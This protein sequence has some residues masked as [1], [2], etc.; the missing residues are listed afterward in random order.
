MWASE[1]SNGYLYLASPSRNH[2][3]IKETEHCSL[4]HF[5][6]L[7]KSV[8]LRCIGVINIFCG[9]SAIHHN[10]TLS[11][12][13][14]LRYMHKGIGVINIWYCCGC[15]RNTL[16]KIN[17]NGSIPSLK[18]DIFS[19]EER[20]YYLV[21]PYV[22][23]S[24]CKEVVSQYGDR[25]WDLLVS[26][27]RPDE[28][29]SKLGLCIAAYRSR[30]RSSGIEMV[31]EEKYRDNSFCE[32][33]VMPNV[34]L[35]I[36]DKP[37]NLDHSTTDIFQH[38]GAQTSVHSFMFI[39][40]LLPSFSTGLMRI[41]WKKTRLDLQTIQAAR[42][43]IACYFH[44]RYKSRTYKKNGTSSQITYDIGSIYGFF[45][46]DNLKVGDVVVKNQDFIEATQESNLYFVSAKFDGTLGLGFQ[47]NMVEQDVVDEKVLMR[48]CSLS[49][50]T[51]IRRHK[52]VEK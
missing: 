32:M 47:Y 17:N 5:T 23:P 2:F 22:L 34:T 16:Q 9:K 48:R 30:S 50:T 28:V 31:T 11:L 18:W 51:Q 40:S 49:G 27:V 36:G 4:L 7:Y 25:I 6:S 52:R 8:P 41:G 21:Q 13:V 45:S 26:K 3:T 19:L 39:C 42:K 1:K 35:T 38:H 20:H 14:P 46:Q 33:G 15:W 12:G 10:Y 43:E 24:E 37:F 44:S 29:C